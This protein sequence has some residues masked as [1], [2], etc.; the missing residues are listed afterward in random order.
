MTKYVAHNI[1]TLAERRLDLSLQ[2]ILELLISMNKY[3]HLLLYQTRINMIPLPYGVRYLMP[4]LRWYLHISDIPVTRCGRLVNHGRKHERNSV[5]KI[6]EINGTTKL[7]LFASGDILA[8]MEIL[9]DYN[10]SSNNIWQQ[11]MPILF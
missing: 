7:C 6:M 11:L 2:F 9:Y 3:C 5:M 8:G 4:V 1:P 10:N